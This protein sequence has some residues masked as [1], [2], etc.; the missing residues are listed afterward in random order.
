MIPTELMPML[1]V[2]PLPLKW[3]LLFLLSNEAM[4]GAQWPPLVIFAC[5][6]T[7]YLSHAT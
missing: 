7:F 1:K 6:S 4:A 3:H 5:F 2:W